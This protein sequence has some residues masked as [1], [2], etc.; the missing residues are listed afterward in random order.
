MP[1]QASPSAQGQFPSPT[2]GA[3]GRIIYIVQPGDSCFR[4]QALYGITVEQL[5]GL[6]PQLDDNCLYSS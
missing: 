4:I 6:N 3:D 5:R 2:P 1:A